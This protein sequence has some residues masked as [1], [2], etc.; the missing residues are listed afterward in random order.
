MEII[1][2]GILLKD[3]E[4]AEALARAIAASERYFLPMVLDRDQLH[5]FDEK[6]K[7]II[8][9]DYNDLEME[10][11]VY[12]CS[13][14]LPRTIVNAAAEKCS[15]IYGIRPHSFSLPR[16]SDEKY[17][18]LI[19][20]T[21]AAGRRGHNIDSGCTRSRIYSILRQIGLPHVA[22]RIP[23]G[24]SYSA[25]ELRRLL[26]ML[27]NSEEADIGEYFEKDAGGVYRACTGNGHKPAFSSGRRGNLQTY[28]CG[29]RA[30]R[31]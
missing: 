7:V 10:N 13:F 2:L 5:N 21:S 27:C 19:A 24:N 11:A 17:A 23:E 29:C 18:K 22:F 9:T 4:Y 16:L 6:E 31:F 12:I 1:S 28:R 30:G 25:R 14:M 20:V 8:I 26:F 15:S 3:R